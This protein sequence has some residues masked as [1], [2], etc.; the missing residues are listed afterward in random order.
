MWNLWIKLKSLFI[1]I[2]I[3]IEGLQKT[4]RRQLVDILLMALLSDSYF[5]CFF[6]YNYLHFIRLVIIK[7]LETVDK[8]GFE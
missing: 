1:L 4:I 2:S 3:Y 6:W 8:N 5:T 7:I